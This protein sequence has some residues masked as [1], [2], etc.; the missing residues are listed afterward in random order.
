MS[1]KLSVP[2]RGAVDRAA[3]K[4]VTAKSTDDED[5]LDTVSRWRAAHAIPLNAIQMAVRN[6]AIR[7]CEQPLM[8]QR[9]KRLPTILDK[10]RRFPQ[11]T[12]TRFQDIGGC[13]A[14]VVN[15]DQLFELER[16]HLKSRTKHKLIREK[17]YVATPRDSGYRS[18][19][20]IYRYN[21][22]SNAEYAGLQI[23]VQ[24]R[25]R[26]Q[27]AWATAVETVSIITRQALKSNEGQERWLRFFAL[28]ASAFAFLER[29]PAV[30]GVPSHPVELANELKF[31][32]HS[33][34]VQSKLDAFRRA[35][36]AVNADA[37]G[38]SY[39]L[40]VLVPSKNLLNVFGFRSEAL[41]TAVQR[42]KEEEQRFSDT[43]TA[44]VVLVGAESA[45][46]L[47]KAYPNFFLD[48]DH[49][50]SQL[51]VA[52]RR[53]GNA[54]RWPS[55]KRVIRNPRQLEMKFTNRKK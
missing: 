23:E 40:M 52:V 14:V 47:R 38:A 28:A 13:R 20:L 44:Q 27:H 37:K 34:K 33:L 10:L 8:A 25:T 17:D 50:L 19:H 1:K 45:Q 35:L 24:L 7:V 43:P 26:L 49:F 3:V 15:L 51:E 46:S 22:E 31:L 12:L 9:L 55:P 39:F 5:S 2:S 32:M 48:T 42:Y 21:S 18:I 54:Q 4:L 16:L 29:C 53:L 36:R 30:P 11:T 6:R 41:P